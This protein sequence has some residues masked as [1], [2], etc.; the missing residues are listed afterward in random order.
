MNFIDLVL[1][2][3]FI[4]AIA[5][6]FFQGMIRLL[7]V[8]VSLYLA[9]VLASLYYAPL[10]EFFVRSFGSER[11]VAQYIGFTIVLMLAF[12]FLTA[13]GIYTFRYAQLPGSLEYLD[14]VIG[15][16]LGMFFGVILIGILSILMWNLMIARGGQNIGL[17]LFSMLGN[18]IANSFVLRYFA[19][20]LLPL[21]YNY[22]DPILPEAA[23]LLF[24][25]R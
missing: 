4:G 6:G 21:A 16:L 25:V 12:I 2:L 18:S 3:L 10:G 11:F 20:V 19:T 17:P 15:T 5:A 24:I 9:I 1:I 8:I 22:I 7:I 23:N 14:R 13:A